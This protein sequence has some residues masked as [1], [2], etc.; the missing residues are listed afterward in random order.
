MHTQDT[1][2][3]SAP[4]QVSCSSAGLGVV[5]FVAVLTDIP[6]L[7][8]NACH[9]IPPTPLDR[10][11]AHIVP[12]YRLKMR[13]LQINTLKFSTS[14][15]ASS[16]PCLALAAKLFTWF[17]FDVKRSG[18]QLRLSESAWVHCA[19][20]LSLS[21]LKPCSSNKRFQYLLEF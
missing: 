1:H 18:L 21:L 2:F 5:R 16:S 10:P 17:L 6:V 15:M 7:V 12:F 20:A 8:S 13:K 14:S 9:F 3:H 4:H 11:L 19:K